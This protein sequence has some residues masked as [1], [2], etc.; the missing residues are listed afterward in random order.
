MTLPPG[1]KNFF[2]IHTQSYET[3]LSH[4]DSP[5]YRINITNQKLCLGQAFS[6]G[7]MYKD[8]LFSKSL[9][10]RNNL[11]THTHTHTPC[12]YFLFFSQ[13]SLLLHYILH[14]SLQYWQLLQKNLR[15][16]VLLPN[17]PK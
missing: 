15:I 2:S 9:P 4:T 13:P 7:L 16:F 10:I 11:H 8:R 5:D 12:C 14:Y 1:L 3:I 17:S 6:V